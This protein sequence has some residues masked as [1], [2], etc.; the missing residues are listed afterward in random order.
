MLF[1]PKASKSEKAA[2]NKILK[3]LR[4]WGMALIPEGELREGE[5][6]FY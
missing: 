4:E 5:E 2:K 1:D 3:D 6:L